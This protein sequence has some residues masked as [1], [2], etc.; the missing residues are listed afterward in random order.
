MLFRSRGRFVGPDRLL[1]SL[2]YRFPVVYVEEL[3]SIEGHVGMH[4]ASVYDDVARQFSPT[5]S[6]DNDQTVGGTTEPLRPAASAG[7][8]IAV[9]SRSHATLEV[10]VGVSPEGG[11]AAK[12]S[13]V[14]PLQALRYSHHTSQTLR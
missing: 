6:F 10:A 4:L 1:G 9:P 5:V 3:V 13:F 11:S 7:L 2:L 8:R 12:V 14:R